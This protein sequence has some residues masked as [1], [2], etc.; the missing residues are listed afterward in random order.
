M[1]IIC[2]GS[3]IALAGELWGANNDEWGDT[4]SEKFGNLPFWVQCMIFFG[5]GFVSCHLVRWTYGEPE[6]TDVKIKGDGNVVELH[7]E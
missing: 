7:E 4:I 3:I 6:K 1:T 5:F 2:I